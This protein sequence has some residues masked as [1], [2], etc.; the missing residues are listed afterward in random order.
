M[1]QRVKRRLLWS[2]ESNDVCRRATSQMTS[3]VE[4]R[5]KRRQLNQEDYHLFHY[6]LVYAEDLYVKLCQM[7]LISLRRHDELLMTEKRQMRYRYYELLK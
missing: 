3:V 2:N 5:V 6:S 7:P 1:E 4:Q